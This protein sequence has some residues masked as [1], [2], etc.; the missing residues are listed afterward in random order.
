MDDAGHGIEQ[1]AAVICRVA[2]AIV[3]ALATIQITLIPRFDT[4]TQFKEETLPYYIRIELVNHV[5]QIA[6]TSG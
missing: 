5:S 2:P 3:S 6:A 1:L 4:I